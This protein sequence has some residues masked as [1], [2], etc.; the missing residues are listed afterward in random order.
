MKFGVAV[1]TSVCPATEAEAQ[2]DYVT[3]LAPVIEDAGYDS[4]WVSDRTVFPSDLAARY[5]ETYGPGRSNPDA[6]NVLEA[7]TV[8]SYVAGATRRARLGISV[9]VLPFRNPVL[10]AK[11]VTTLDVLTGGRVIFGVGVGWMPEEF[12][13]MGAS[14]PNRGALTD[15]HIEMFKALCAGGTPEYRGRHFQI[16]GM[17]F[18]PKPVQR[19]HPPIWVGGNTRAALRRTAR[20]GDNWHCIRL[21][22]GEIADGT[23]TLRRLCEEYGRDPDSVSV[24]LRT[25][26][27]IGEAQRV[28]N[29]ERVPLTGDADQIIDDLR[30]YQEV[31]LEYVVLSVAAES[32]EA[33]TNAVQ[34]FA[35]QIAPKV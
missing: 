2:A 28:E 17:T 34:R 7:L 4:I 33:T 35:D 26:V 24:S 29:G 9:L 14:Y 21:T 12:A 5:P 1:T 16:D 23:R 27:Q 15:E 8:L 13:A 11:M 30:E 3:R 31:G 19:P 6:Q 10:N 25:T 32:T 22:P 18:F 20:L